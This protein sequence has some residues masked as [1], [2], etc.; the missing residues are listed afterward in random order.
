MLRNIK[1]NEN[2]KK[3]IK[4]RKAKKVYVIKNQ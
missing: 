3:K 1:P 2:D 4:V